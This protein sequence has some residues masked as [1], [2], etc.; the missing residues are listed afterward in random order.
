L[1]ENDFNP[2]NVRFCIMA[3]CKR[4]IVECIEYCR[5]IAFEMRREMK[6]KQAEE[7]QK[8]SKIYNLTFFKD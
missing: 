5:D 2:N 6:K 1:W 4:K 3:A 7:K 8:R